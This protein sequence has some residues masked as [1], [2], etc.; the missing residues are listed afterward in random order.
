MVNSNWFW[1]KSWVAPALK[2]KHSRRFREQRDNEVTVELRNLAGSCPK[3]AKALR[4]APVGDSEIYSIRFNS[5]LDMWELTGPRESGVDKTKRW[6][7]WYAAKQL[8]K[9]WETDCIESRLDTYK[10]DGS[11]QQSRQY[12]SNL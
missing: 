5:G 10:R 2:N 4:P 8:R 3:C 6:L 11:F 9:H 12:G 7:V 1:P